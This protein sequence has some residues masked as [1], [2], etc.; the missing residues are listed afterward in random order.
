MKLPAPFTALLLAGSLTLAV[1]ACGTPTVE[2]AESRFKANKDKISVLTT[3]QPANKAEFDKKIAEFD[4]EHTDAMAAGTDEE[5]IK[6]LG[7]L[8]S[9]MDK[10][11]AELE[12]ANPTEPAKAGGAGAPS[13]K[14][15]GAAAPAA[16]APPAGGKL[17]GTAPAAQ[18]ASGGMGGGAAPAA[19]PASGGMGGGAAPAA[20]PASGGMGGM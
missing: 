15:D 10:Y 17:D 11:I 3:K 6:K 18:P 4:K 1:A 5:K 14:L 20:Q 2:G 13:N 7:A 9:R 19:Q 8:N 16:G 12:K